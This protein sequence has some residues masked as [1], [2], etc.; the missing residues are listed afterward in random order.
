MIRKLS[1]VGEAGRGAFGIVDVCEDDR[2][3][4]R[5]ARKRIPKANNMFRVRS[6]VSIMTHLSDTDA[7]VKI[8]DIAQDEDSVYIDMEWC[9]GGI[10]YKQ[11]LPGGAFEAPLPERKAARVFLDMLS[12]TNHIHD[13]GVCHRDIKPEN[14]LLTKNLDIKLSDFG[15]SSFFITGSPLRQRVGSPFYV[16]PEVLE[17]RYG[18]AADIW[19]LG[20]IL[21]ILLSGS[22]P[23]YGDT[24][25][26][27]FEAVSTQEPDTVT[28]VWKD[29][30]DGAKDLVRRLLCKDP[31]E[32]ITGSR[33]MT[34]EWM[35]SFGFVVTRRMDTFLFGM[36]SFFAHEFDRGLRR[37]YGSFLQAS[38]EERAEEMLRQ[39]PDALRCI[40]RVMAH[41]RISPDGNTTRFAARMVDTLK[42]VHDIDLVDV[43]LKTGCKLVAIWLFGLV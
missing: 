36:S 28:G 35:R 12:V 41:H 8:F 23:F 21:Y 6:E 32:R 19:S 37:V 30:S 24:M 17:R 5:V 27:I 29:V 15:L 2:T 39:F 7:V 40:N 13:L 9:P 3:G 18:P 14:F 4:E 25:D 10:L 34:H 38:S 22:F 11:V 42:K 20:I 1:I 33:A 43:A 31:S 16:A 26:D